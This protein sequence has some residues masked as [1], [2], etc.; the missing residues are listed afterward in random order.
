MKLTLQIHFDQ[1]WHDA[2]EVSLPDPERG[3]HGA[4]RLRYAAD[5]AVEWMFHDDLHASSLLLPVELMLA[6]ECP[7]WFGF[8]EDIMPAGASRRFWVDYLGIHD[9][10]VGRQ[11]AELL[12]RGTIAPVG[13]L[14]IK[15]AVPDDS[16]REVLGEC[17][18][19]VQSV[20]ERDVDFLEY[21]QQMGAASGGAT[22]AGG[23]AP[24]LLLRLAGDEQVWID[25]WQDEVHRPD[26]PMLV[27]FPRGSRSADDCDILRAEYYYYQEL[28]AL[29]ID[30]I[31]TT[32]M[33]LIEGERYPS[34]WLPRFDRH[35]RY[36]AW[37]RY[38]LESV[39]SLMG[40]APGT[41]LRHGETLRRLVGLLQAQYRV[42]ELGEAFDTQA[43]VIEWVRRDLLNIAF[44]NSD[45]HGRNMALLKRPEGIGLAPVYDFAPMRADPDG[46]TRTT[47]WGP[48]L[49][50][51]REY[52]WHAIAES[53]S[54]L[55]DPEQLMETFRRLAADLD[56]LDERL[57]ARGVPPRILDMPSVGL[58]SLGTRLKRW[59]ML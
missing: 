51:G 16:L 19:P 27:K 36:G 13:N 29:G 30:T 28:T 38:G 10:P 58:R 4:S 7:R 39:Y 53:L 41:F 12:A 11:D 50:A 8:L 21:A 47:Q 37:A 33:R 20:V 35:Y 22:G 26:L 32:S 52:D 6:H 44:G 43:F 54:D 18:F 56:G 57:A 49:E 34:L 3:I 48:P 17:R 5:Y 1:H 46:G 55:V 14:R 45:N 31:D 23:E 59:G 40:A 25:T 2:A 9:L 42:R 24:K 15:E